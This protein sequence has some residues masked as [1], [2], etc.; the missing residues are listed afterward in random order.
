MVNIKILVL[1]LGAVSLALASFG[2]RVGKLNL[3]WFGM[4]LWILSLLIR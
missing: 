3:G 2:V 1:I 4:F